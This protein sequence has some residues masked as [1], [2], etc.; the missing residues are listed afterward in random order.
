MIIL[1]LSGKARTGKST[2]CKEL[3]DAAER[4]GW[5][6]QIKPFAGPLKKHV[7][8][9]LGYTKDN[10]PEMYRQYCQKIGA[11]ERQRDPDH[12]VKLW[13]QDMI[14]EF[15]QEMSSSKRPVLYLVDDVRYPNELK[16][17]NQSNINATILFVKHGNRTIEDPNGQWRQH[18]SEKLANTYETSSNEYLKNEIGYHFVVHNDKTEQDI[19]QWATNFINYLASW[20]PCLCETCVANYEMREPNTE[21]I[22]EELKES[23][24]DL[25]GDD[26]EENGDA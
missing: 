20:D 6:V 13:Y 3:Y 26:D 9:T 24:D 7:A 22:D 15:Q 10:N 12:W 11:Q 17:L 16:A 8:N 2:L 23:L 21:K 19:K 25:L 1:G 5:D 14:K 18:E 4:V